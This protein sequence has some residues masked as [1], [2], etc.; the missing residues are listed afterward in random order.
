MRHEKYNGSN[1]KNDDMSGEGPLDLT[2]S[3]VRVKNYFKQIDPLDPAGG[4]RLGR[5]QGS[6][7]FVSAA[8][9]FITNAHVVRNHVRLM[10]APSTGQPGKFSAEV[11]SIVPSVDLALCRMRSTSGSAFSVVP[12]V[13][14]DAMALRGGVDEIVVYGYP[15][16][17][18]QLHPTRGVFGGWESVGTGMLLRTDAALNPGN[19]GGAMTDARGRVVAV[20][21]GKKLGA[22]GIEFGIPAGAISR[23]SR[24]EV[25]DLGLFFGMLNEKAGSAIPPLVPF[26]EGA[27]VRDLRFG[28]SFQSVSRDMGAALPFDLPEGEGVMLTNVYD[29]GKTPKGNTFLSR[30][31]LGR[32]DVLLSIGG[33]KIKNDGTVLNDRRWG[34][35]AELESEFH[36]LKNA[37]RTAVL[38][39]FDRAQDTEK[40]AEVSLEPPREPLPIRFVHRPQEPR[41]YAVVGGV[42]LAELSMDLLLLLMDRNAILVSFLKPKNRTQPRLVVSAVRPSRASDSGILMPGDVVLS[43]NSVRVGTVEEAE[44]ALLSPPPGKGFEERVVIVT[45]GDNKTEQFARPVEAEIVRVGPTVETRR[46]S[47]GPASERSHASSADRSETAARMDL[48]GDAAAFAGA[49]SF[50]GV[51]VRPEMFVEVIGQGS[52]GQIRLHRHENLVA[53]F[54]ISGGCVRAETEFRLMQKFHETVTSWRSLFSEPLPLKIAVANPVKFVESQ[55]GCYSVMSR[56]LSPRDDGLALHLTFGSFE[57]HLWNKRSWVE[58]DRT[59]FARPDY[60]ADFLQKFNASQGT[61]YGI[62]DVYA[63]M[64]TATCLLTLVAGTSAA[65]VEYVLGLDETQTNRL[66]LYVMDFGSARRVGFDDPADMGVTLEHLVFVGSGY[67]PT[68]SNLEGWVQTASAFVRCWMTEESQPAAVEPFKLDGSYRNRRIVFERTLRMLSD[69]LC[70]HVEHLVFRRRGDLWSRVLRMSS[71]R[72]HL[73]E[74]M[75]SLRRLRSSCDGV[76][77]LEPAE[78][79]RATRKLVRSFAG[80]VAKEVETNISPYPGEADAFVRD[81]LRKHST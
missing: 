24:G 76:L 16:G 43:V 3:M 50:G 42:V 69:R 68:A 10:V 2:R 63:A 53:K 5:L 79:W 11:L 59:F 1:E 60:A 72:R 70:A 13:F 81:L 20:S 48:E 55:A 21:V 30:A 36:A 49:V 22:D 67:L 8:G 31:G 65:D 38:R 34:N 7:F 44:R 6:G 29:Y 61:N 57:E 4:S 64:G 19:S 35:G 54:V 25:S 15:L 17:T 39:F 51:D 12:V 56:V 18:K 52:W 37:Q 40:V 41:R 66:A 80:E 33:M 27:I 74:K 14:G 32:G 75:P 46:I 77:S 47:S 58:N 62:G 71:V 45:L 26:L 73:E 28:G 9:H 78:A 23:F